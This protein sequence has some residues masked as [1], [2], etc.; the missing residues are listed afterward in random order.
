VVKTLVVLPEDLGS[1]P[2]PHKAAYNLWLL[3][4]Q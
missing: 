2:K 1:I 3:Q 4:T